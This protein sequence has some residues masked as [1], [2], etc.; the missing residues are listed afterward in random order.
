MWQRGAA[1]SSGATPR[2]VMFLVSFSLGKFLRHGSLST[3]VRCCK[4]LPSSPYKRPVIFSRQN[5]ATSV[6][7][8]KMFWLKT[9]TYVIFVQ[10]LLISVYL[11]YSTKILAKF[12]LRI[13]IQGEVVIQFNYSGVIQFFVYPILSAGMSKR[14][15]I[16]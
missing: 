4:T 12:Y 6:G 7:F 16:Y 11:I 13:C 15:W 2:L 5:S 9:R 14:R 8:L 1:Q 3:S 10:I